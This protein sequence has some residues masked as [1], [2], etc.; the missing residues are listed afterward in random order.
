MV[1]FYRKLHFYLVVSSYEGTPNPALEAASCGVPI[2]TTSV[3][4]MP[5]LIKDG[6]NGFFV[7]CKIK[8]IIKKIQNI[9]SI[10]LEEYARMSIRI[11][12]NIVDNWDWASVVDKY[13]EF[14]D[15]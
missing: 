13:E 3:G 8:D 15:E 4:N 14:F 5:E 2:I 1:N 11:R 9:S 10:D 7:K 12:Q 6:H